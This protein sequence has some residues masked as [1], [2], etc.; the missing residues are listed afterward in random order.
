LHDNVEEMRTPKI[1]SSLNS[2]ILRWAMRSYTS[3]SDYEDKYDFMAFP[4]VKD[5]LIK[6]AEELETI[7]DE[8]SKDKI[9]Y[10]ASLLSTASLKIDSDKFRIL[11]LVSIIEAMLTRNPDT[12]KFNVE[13]S[14]SKQFKLKA[15]II[16]YLNDRTKN[17]L[18]IKKR[19]TDIY[20]Q[21]SNIAHGNI[22][23][24]ETYL[25]KEA[26]KIKED[27]FWFTGEEM[28]IDGLITDLYSFT[29]AIIEEYIKDR[30]LVEFIKEN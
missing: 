20:G 10:I 4:L 2:S 13:D 9:L 17:L 11:T 15:G 25:K 5:I 23:G 12:S 27:T 6:K 29:K 21:R 7:L 16:I 18:D 28:I 24:F 3:N 22:N 26:K 30:D 14:I 8:K 19:L 1:D